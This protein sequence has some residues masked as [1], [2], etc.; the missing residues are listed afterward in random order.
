MAANVSFRSGVKAAPVALCKP[1]GPAA[2][3]CREA[4]H[5]LRKQTLRVERAIHAAAVSANG[6]AAP[7]PPKTTSPK[8]IVFVAAEVAPWSKTGGLGDV[9]GG[10]PVELAKRG[11]NVMTV[12]P[13]CGASRPLRARSCRD[14]L[15]PVAYPE[16]LLPE[17]IKYCRDDSLRARAGGSRVYSGRGPP[18]R[19]LRCQLVGAA[20]GTRAAR[21][22]GTLEAFEQHFWC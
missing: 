8:N 7:A 16:D 19:H 15:G 6:A 5:A 2:G 17:N 14:A 22:P 1:R 20:R 18:G 13:R 4:R 21:H 9:V 11:H 12:A 3:P 10:L